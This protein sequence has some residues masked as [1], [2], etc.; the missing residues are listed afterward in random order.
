MKIILSVDF[1]Y[2]FDNSLG[3]VFIVE[4][5]AMFNGVI[6]LNFRKLD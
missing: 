6:F 1:G 3:R 4:P 5:G 2:W